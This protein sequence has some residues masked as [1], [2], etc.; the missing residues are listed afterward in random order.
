M[1][2]ERFQNSNNAFYEKQERVP[3][4]PLDPRVS[5]FQKYSVSSLTWN[6][7]HSCTYITLISIL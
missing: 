4:S 1:T 7:Y 2:S 6:L 3:I 5:P